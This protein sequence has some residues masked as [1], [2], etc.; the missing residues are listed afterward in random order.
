MVAISGYRGLIG[1]AVEKKLREKGIDVIALSRDDLYDAE[2]TI[3]REKLS[4]CQ[5]VIHLAGAPVLQRWTKKNRKIIYESRVVTT[6]NLVNAINKLPE[7]ERPR[8]FLSASAVGIYRN[9]LTHTEE[10][11]DFDDHFAAQVTTGW[12]KSSGGLSGDVRRVIFR[13]GLVLDCESQ[14]I[15]RLWLPFNAG[16]GGAIGSGRQPFPFIHLHDL[17]AAFIMAIENHHFRGIY[18]LVAPDRKN[19]RQFSE[20]LAK[21]MHRPCWFSVPAFAMRILFGRASVMLLESPG[22]IPGKLVT[23]GFAFRYST[24]ESALDE[25]VRHKKRLPLPAAS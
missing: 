19:N 11:T 15:K 4:G 9:G 18:N 17:T 24:L 16:F 13:T 7:N 12:E 8:L 20:E 10:S 22:V 2:G 21:K 5:A 6:E 1:S 14:I 3:L 23:E 25:I